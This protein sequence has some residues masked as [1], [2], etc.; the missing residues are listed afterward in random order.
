MNLGLALERLGRHDEAARTYM[1]LAGAPAPHVDAC[2]RLGALAEERNELEQADEWVARAL[3]LAPAN[4][5]ANLTR[6]QLDARAD[7]YD[8]AAQR[9]QRLL[10]QPLSATNEA[11]AAGRLGRA[12]DRLG[13]YAAAFAAV[14]RG[15]RA[16]ARSYGAAADGDGPYS[17]AAI[18]RLR[19]FFDSA[20]MPAGGAS[21]D[22]R[23]PVFLIG[24]PRSGTTLLDRMLAAHPAI[25][26]L[27]EQETLAAIKRDFLMDEGGL[28]RLWALPAEAMERYRD[29]YWRDVD[30]RLPGAQKSTVVDKLPLN[31]IFAGL[32]HRVFP[33][34]KFI[35]AL[36]DPRDV[37]LS[38]F[39]QTFGGN[40]AMRHL[41]DLDTIGTYYA[42]VMDLVELY[43]E[44]LPLNLAAVRYEEVVAD[45]R[46][47]IEPLL[48]FLDRPWNDA[49]L[50]YRDKLRGTR[51]DTPSYHQVSRP[52]YG[53]AIGR[54]RH[55]R[56]QLAPLL[57][58]LQP[59][60][61]RFGYQ[62]D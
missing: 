10:E 23:T 40:E 54:W 57:P 45:P 29:A 59:F 49:I 22:T 36:R 43:R 46:G 2:A 41:L 61:E 18:A 39:M 35:L 8:A 13:E 28:A 34:A 38:C 50:S 55:Y 30:A 1:E 51:I 17:L 47:A 26:V 6:A 9:L 21:T 37:C 52:L 20:E 5:V 4:V 58:R 25:A 24:F 27:E 12:F 33:N 3:A 48:A 16:L 14:Q 11:I 7:R 62:P 53:S 19:A 56:E 15:N 60:V 32:I 31:A 44:R 42:A